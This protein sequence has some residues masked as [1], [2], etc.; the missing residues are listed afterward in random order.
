LVSTI[1]KFRPLPGPAGTDDTLKS[2]A[3][4]EEYAEGDTKPYATVER[5]L[6]YYIRRNIVYEEGTAKYTP[7]GEPWNG[8]IELAGCWP[9][10]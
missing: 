3:A 2:W 10:Q 8:S 4:F 1:G 6:V 7:M 5:H 9:R